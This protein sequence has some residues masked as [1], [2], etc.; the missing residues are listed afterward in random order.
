MSKLYAG[1]N[2]TSIGTA[3][4]GWTDS[5]GTYTA[6]VDPGTYAHVDFP[7]VAW[8]DAYTDFATALKAAM[9]AA[10]SVNFTVSYDTANMT[11]NFQTNPA[12]G[13]ITLTAST[14]SV[15]RNILGFNS[16]P[17]G[18]SASI[19]SQI[20]PYYVIDPYT[21]GQSMVSPRRERAIAADGEADA[22]AAYGVSATAY[23]IY[24]D[25]TQTMEPDEVV[26]SD[27]ADASVPWT[28]EHLFQHCRNVEPIYN[29]STID[30][31]ATASYLIRAEGSAFDPQRVTADY[32]GQWNIPFKC[33]FIA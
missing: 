8:M 23:P 10:S 33:R 1:F 25:F 15:M 11:Y 30:A 18:P 6:S 26:Y 19:T 7:T 28:Y 27:R 2:T 17:T 3:T 21:D 22:G 14:N 24:F 9:E 32:D 4:I 12:G 29:V 5:S 31:N 16:L 13:N 20:R